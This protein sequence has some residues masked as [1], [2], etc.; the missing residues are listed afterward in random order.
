MNHQSIKIC[1]ILAL[2]VHGQFILFLSPPAFSEQNSLKNYS[3]FLAAPSCEDDLIFLIS[4]DCSLYA[5]DESKNDVRWVSKLDP[6]PEN[7]DPAFLPAPCPVIAG[8]YLIIHLGRKLWVVSRVDGRLI[9]SID[10]LPLTSSSVIHRSYNSS[11]GF[12]VHEEEPVFQVLTLEEDSGLWFLRSRQLGDGGIEW[13]APILKEPKAWWLTKEYII[14]ATERLPSALDEYQ[15]K[16]PGVLNKVSLDSGISVWKSET[17]LGNSFCKALRCETRSNPR[18]YLI[19]KTLEAGF[20][21]RAFNEDSGELYRTITIPQGEFIDALQAG[22]KLI[23]LFGNEHGKITLMLYYSSL[24]LIRQK[25]VEKPEESEM[26]VPAIANGTLLL[27]GCSAYSLYDGNK[28][29]EFGQEDC[30]S[31]LIGWI[32]T[33]EHLYRWTSDTKLRC[34][35]RLTG[36]DIWQIEIPA[37]KPLQSPDD[38]VY[39]ASLVYSSGRILAATPDGKLYRVN[40]ETGKVHPGVIQISGS[41]V[42]DVSSQ[43]KPGSHKIWLGLIAGLVIVIML[44]FIIKIRRKQD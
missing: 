21:V 12:F 13:E 33:S 24:N 25:T 28:V 31:K 8:S 26:F 7:I 6:Q 4:A 34:F 9:W 16:Y 35:D 29:W 43:N 17:Q 20:Q 5:F 38:P 10:G 39:G 14:Y 15:D 19:E 2:A 23:F 11:P 37:G 1:L 22:D 36:D 41:S 44:S 3:G 18:I 27:Y 42:V 32:S 30:T 40:A